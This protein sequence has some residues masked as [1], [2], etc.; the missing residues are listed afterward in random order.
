M[1][2][3]APARRALPI[4]WA[5]L[6]AACATPGTADV[7]EAVERVIAPFETR[8]ECLWLDAGERLDWWFEADTPV[9]F[10][11]RYRDAN[12]MLIP[13]TRE[14]VKTDAGIYQAVLSHRYCGAW[15][16]GP[17]GAFIAFRLRRLPAVQ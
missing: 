6:A 11:I 13:L 17:G 3:A 9:T 7:R 12:A 15:E 1:I 8:E 4:A 16:S 10:D 5:A 2:G 14:N